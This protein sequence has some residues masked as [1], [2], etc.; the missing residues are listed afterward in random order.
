V[1]RRRFWSTVAVVVLAVLVVSATALWLALPR[2]AR[3]A[4]VRQVEAQTG[5]R[6]TMAQFD[7]D[8][9]HG[10]LHIAGFRLEDRIPGPPL[11]EFDRLDVRFHPTR[12]LRG[13]LEIADV[14]LAGPR[15]HIV[16][17]GQGELN[18]SDL[19]ARPASRS[20]SPPFTLDRLAVNGGAILFEDRTLTPTRIWRAEALT[21]EADTLSSASP[22]P[23]GRLRITAT[24]AGAPFSLD[25][26]GIA[27]RPLQAKARVS[28]RDADA[29]LANLYLPADTM[30][31]LERA[32]AGAVVDATLDAQGGVGLDGQARIADVVARRRGV[33]AS[34][35]TV[36]ALTVT[37]KS[38]RS[39]EGRLVDRVEVNGQATVFDPRPGKS[40]RFEIQRLRVVADGLDAT[41]RSSARLTASA[42]LPGGGALDVQGT[43][44]A[45]PAAAEIRTRISKVDL[46]FWAPY[47]S[48]PVDFT[49]M[50]E[51][52][53][54]FDTTPAGPRVRGRALVKAVTVSAG[55]RRLAAADQ[56]ELSGLDAQWPK[57][58]VERVTLS[59]PRARIGRDRDGRLTI[60]ELVESMKKPADQRPAEPIEK[61]S[62]LPPDFALE[63]GEVSVED[64]RLRLDDATVEPAAV[65]RL[66]PIRLTARTLTWPSR[67]PATVTLS[68][69]TPGGGTIET[70]GTVALDPVRFD[71]RTRLVDV[72][73]APYRPYAP[74]AARVDGHVEG[75]LTARGT[76]GGGK[77][78]LSAKGSLALADLAFIDGDRPIL[79]VGRLDLTGLDYTWPAAA[80]ID[81]VHM[82]KSWALLERRPDG[83]MPITGILTPLRRAPP[84]DAPPAPPSS[85]A[86]S[87]S[88]PPAAPSPSSPP[89]SASPEIR[90]TA[91][92][93]LFEDGAATVVDA[94]V[95][96]TARLEVNGVRLNVRDFAW[97]A[98]AP[99][100]VQLEAP[101]PGAGRITARGTLDLITQSLQMQITPAGVDLGPAQPYLPVRGRL[102][103]QASGDLALQATLSPWSLTARGTA[104]IADMALGEAGKPLMTAARLQATGIDYAWPATVTVD[105]LD[106]QKP[107]A[108]I[109]QAAD[110]SFPLRALLEPPAPPPGAPARPDAPAPSGGAA[111]LDLR[112]RRAGVDGGVFEII[113]STVRPTARA[114]I[115]DA[116]L[117]IRN[118]TWPAREPSRLR[119][120]ATTGTGGTV[121]A[122]GDLR[123][124]T[125]AIDLQL[126][127]KQLDVA[128]AQ[129]FVP[130]RASLAGK[131]DADLRVKGTLAP[132]SVAATGRV[133][134]DDPILGDG[135]RMLGY[136]KRVDMD[137]IDAD[138]PRRVAIQRMALEQPWALVERDVDGG[139]PLIDLLTPN[140]PTSVAPAPAPVPRRE[141][142]SPGPPPPGEGALPVVTL[143][144]VTVSEGFVRFVD[145]TT[146]P[147]FAEEASRIALDGRGLTTAR[148]GAG[149]LTMAGRL[150]GGAP[151][152][153]KGT[154][155][156]L[157]GPLNLDLEGKLTD[158]PLPRVN[159]YANKLIGWIAR[160][161]AFGSTVRYRVVDDVLTAS[162]EIVLGQPDF[163][164]SKSGDEVRDRVGVP[165][166]TLIALLKNA[167]GEV[168]L[169]VPVTGN[170]ATRQFDFTDAFWDAVRKTAVGVMALPVSWV[171]K[172][173]YSADARVETIQIWPV[174]FEAGTTR[175]APGFDRHADRLGG[176]L[177]DAPGVNLAMKSVLTVDDIAALKRDA[178]LRRIEAAGRE[179]PGGPAAAAARLYT[180]RHPGET[181]PGDVDAIVSDLVK[182]EPS[183]DAAAKALS[184]QRMDVTRTQLQKARVAP[185]RLHVTEGLVPVEG[186]GL[187]RVEFEI[188]P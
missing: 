111:P 186:S 40:N 67:G 123:L 34:L 99:V 4:V 173:F 32:V 113:D 79:T 66:A 29:T 76:V 16:R 18:I 31:V 5:R 14:A 114:Q 52:D 20:E 77:T 184:A 166:G 110:G 147:A 151:F 74:L 68:A 25:A 47:V 109:E 125:R 22:E 127:I 118:F 37:F 183:P 89:A 188:A 13:H 172:I 187:G 65:F 165:L 164:P 121:D 159:P 19:L 145:R 92:E 23:R 180:E 58:K 167:R 170:V 55:I 41:G 84:A 21:V 80:S 44:R 177:R 140:T 112:V 156:G 15:V 56:L 33:D 46:A 87:P 131:L 163:A 133:A 85:A 176:F 73:V 153:L 139:F 35:F 115:H 42:G 148:T 108:Q 39:P 104:A 69:G 185:Q 144:E 103:G 96:P 179:T 106:L 174:Y 17:I 28:L 100:P 7:L 59:R 30:V 12:L 72:A 24:V 82:R 38:G 63:V 91:R 8:L 132:L 27:L 49:G 175:F 60:A 3:W 81:R 150:T 122:R 143:G 126:A 107:W 160:R 162:N 54:T 101:T 50:A 83:S 88:G 43:A 26:S 116:R 78:E 149:R 61:P 161:G 97:P 2:L 98:R 130:G 128:I 48:L 182:D 135:Q 71:L 9:R 136:V 137:G 158:F 138:W 129:A 64:G 95:S 169:S 142:P 75:D 51:T 119:L 53:L 36:P 90:M 134:V 171:G 10:R 93:V 62:P 181:A 45:N 178:V 124:D 168:R 102:T 155:G 57:A 11:V 152:E 94:A 120:R 117:T 154:V 105:R 141:A 157:G 86:P 146:R 70:E 6:P 1:T